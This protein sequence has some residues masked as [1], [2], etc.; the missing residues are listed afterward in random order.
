[1]LKNPAPA[2]SQPTFLR[3]AVKGLVVV[4]VVTALAAGI[5][6]A[7]RTPARQAE[8]LALNAPGASI[9]VGITPVRVLDTRVPT[10]VPAAGPIPPDTT[11]DVSVAGARGDPRHRH[12]V[13][14]NVAITPEAQAVSFVTMWPTGQPRP[15]SAVNNATPGFISSSA[16]IFQIGIDG[17]LSVYNQAS[18]VNVDDRRDRVLPAGDARVRP[19]ERVR[20]SR[21]GPFVATWSTPRQPRSQT[22]TRSTRTSAGND[23]VRPG[24]DRRPGE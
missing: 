1:M 21:H 3:W 24:F 14:A 17:K 2:T 9:F 8:A 22:G 19:G 23:R 15:L 16:G 11:I 13:A 20:E 18:P 6:A 5:A 12:I 4:V 7:A 10:G